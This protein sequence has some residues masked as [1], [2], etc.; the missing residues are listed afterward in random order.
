MELDFA[1]TPG[2]VHVEQEEHVSE[3]VET[4][5]ETLIGNSPSPAGEDLFGQGAGGLL[6]EDLK[7]KFHT[8][9][10][11]GL[12]IA[13]RSRPDIALVVSV[14]SSRVRSPNKDDWRKC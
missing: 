5:P 10:A 11:K 8:I 7:D 12:F 4:I 14:L 9:V 2:A 3:M 6:N 1:T 13:K